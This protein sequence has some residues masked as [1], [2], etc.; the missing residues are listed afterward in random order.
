MFC[1]VCGSEQL[2]QYCRSCGMDLRRLHSVLEKQDEIK[3]PSISAREEIGRAFADKIRELKSAK[4]LSK[5][6]EEVLPGIESFLASPEEKR[7]N[8]IRSGMIT[9]AVGLGAALAFATLGWFK[10]DSGGPIFVAGLGLTTFL[11]GLGIM[12][13]GWLFTI[14][15]KP[16]KDQES[17]TFAKTAAESLLHLAPKRP[18]AE[19]L[20]TPSVSEHTTHQLSD[21]EVHVRE[22]K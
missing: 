13:N 5:V 22:G 11:I 1:P 14:P 10:E 2:S 17:E 12:L 4:E 3:T 7:L 6:V 9:A 19:R 8:R 16:D 15:K 18:E 20:F 21:S